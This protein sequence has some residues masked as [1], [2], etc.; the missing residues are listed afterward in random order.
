MLSVANILDTESILC[1]SDFIAS[2]ADPLK[3]LANLST[4][5]DFEKPHQLVDSR[6]F[7]MKAG[8][9]FGSSVK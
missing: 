1:S 9:S 7:V 5:S 6:N 3:Y 8:Q 4:F 2:K